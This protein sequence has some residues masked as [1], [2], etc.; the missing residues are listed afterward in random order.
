MQGSDIY[1]PVTLVARRVVRRVGTDTLVLSGLGRPPL[2]VGQTVQ[3]LTVAVL[4]DPDLVPV[5]RVD[6]RMD[7]VHPYR[8]SGRTGRAE[9]ESEPWG[10]N[11]KQPRTEI[12]SEPV[13][14]WR[15]GTTVEDRNPPD[16][17]PGPGPGSRL[18]RR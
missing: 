4:V 6:L 11:P 8:R 9:W 12:V 15:R 1:S 16:Y 10:R 18:G 5:R 14:K 17:G 13:T 7:H 2:L 3:T